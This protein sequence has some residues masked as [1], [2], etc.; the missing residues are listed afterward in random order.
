MPEEVR[1]AGIGEQIV[2]LATA[3]VEEVTGLTCGNKK[4]SNYLA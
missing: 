3:A 4:C 2:W 1:K